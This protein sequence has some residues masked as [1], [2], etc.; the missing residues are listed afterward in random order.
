[1]NNL[2][3]KLAPTLVTAIL[4][5][6]SH[7]PSGKRPEAAPGRPEPNCDLTA[8]GKAV[9]VDTAVLRKAKVNFPWQESTEGAS[10]TTY[11]DA[12]VL[13]VLVLSFFGERGKVVSAFY[14]TPAGDFVLVQEEMRYAMP[15]DVQAAPKIV[16][17]LPAVAYYC[18]G[19]PQTALLRSDV[20]SA[21]G[22]LDSA[23]V[24]LRRSGQ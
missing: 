11:T 20:V 22:T 6:A 17:R 24:V 16:S 9:A 3:I 15:I 14:L 19:A 10:M 5:L 13:K 1:M 23:L 4:S 18:G 21:K 2:A 8:L 7:G 12:K